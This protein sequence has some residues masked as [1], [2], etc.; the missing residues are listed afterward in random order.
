[1]SNDTRATIAAPATY[2]EAEAIL[3]R[4]AP[5]T[6]QSIWAD[7][8]REAAEGLLQDIAGA[9]PPAPAA[10]DEPRLGPVTLAPPPLERYAAW[11]VTPVREAPGKT[12]PDG[13]MPEAAEAP[14]LARLSEKTLLSVLE[15]APDAIVVID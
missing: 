13:A 2:V 11:P 6:A 4:L 7:M 5:R 15:T 8:S 9:A 12:D 3:Q 10:D 1:M 14:A